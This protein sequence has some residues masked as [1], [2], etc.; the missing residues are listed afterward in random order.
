MWNDSENQIELILL[1][2]AKTNGNLSYRYIGNRT[3]EDILEDEKR[4][5]EDCDKIEADLV[6]SSPLK[7]CI[8]TALVINNNDKYEIIDEFKEIDFGKFEG[9]NYEELNGDKDYQSFL[10]SGGKTGFVQGESFDE[11]ISRT[12][13]GFNKL[14][15]YVRNNTDSNNG[16]RLSKVLAVVHGGTIM[17]ILSSLCGG[18]YYDYQVGNLCGYKI[19]LNICEDEVECSTVETYT[20]IK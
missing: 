10:D 15:E 18:D 1:R 4:L 17:A 9:K 13:V 20:V 14:I 19:V 6:L 12:L 11:F 2:H 8:Q 16:S 7:R 3:D 5:L